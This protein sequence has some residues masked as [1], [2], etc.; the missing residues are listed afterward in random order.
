M[1]RPRLVL[2]D[3]PTANLDSRTGEMILNE[4]QRV[5]RDL[6][7]TFVFSTHDMV[8]RDMANH[9]VEL[10]DGQVHSET[11]GISGAPAS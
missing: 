8:I 10:K 5:N 4:M 3:E 1:N 2:A 9:V 6:G 7:T 11:S